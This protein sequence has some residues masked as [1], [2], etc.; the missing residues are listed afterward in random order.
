MQRSVAVLSFGLFAGCSQG[1][2]LTFNKKTD[3]TGEASTTAVDTDDGGGTGETIIQEPDYGD[4]GDDDGG[5]SGSGSGT[6][7]DPTYDWSTWTGS[8]TYSI[9]KPIEP[10]C[11]GDVV[12]ESGVRLEVDLE[13]LQDLCPI[14][15]DF[16]EVTYAARSACG[17]DIDLSAPEVRGFVLRGTNL[18]VWRIRG[19][20]ASRDVEIEF[21]D[22]PYE[23]G[24]ATYTFDE[25]W[26]G[27][28]TL[29]VDGSVTFPEVPAP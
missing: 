9:D 4:S 12:A 25:S 8:R 16:Y 10:D 11:S 14:C 24:H 7:D 28:G 13:E 20:G 3:D 21:N 18:E 2:V 26:N 29:V 22:G 19:S 5:G 15:S 17:G 1:S 23:A 6:V 27:E